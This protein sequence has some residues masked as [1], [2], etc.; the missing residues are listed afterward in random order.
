MRV[1]V[2]PHPPVPPGASTFF[3]FN[4]VPLEPPPPPPFLLL[5]L[6]TMSP[7]LPPLQFLPPPAV[8]RPVIRSA[9]GP[10]R[11]WPIYLPPLD[12]NQDWLK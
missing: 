6:F 1:M 10:G 5:P 12:L 11:I 4:P 3:G 7:L 8:L 2:H 9:S